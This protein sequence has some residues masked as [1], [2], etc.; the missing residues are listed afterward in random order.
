MKLLYEYPY[1][2]GRMKRE[3]QIT[4]SPLGK[5]RLLFRL[6]CFSAFICHKN[7]R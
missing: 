5:D 6:I 3:M 7:E 4:A 1:S 2:A